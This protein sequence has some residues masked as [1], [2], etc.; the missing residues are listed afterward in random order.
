MK[1]ITTV[2]VACAALIGSTV[3]PAMTQQAAAQQPA[4]T[5][6]ATA[7]QPASSAPALPDLKTKVSYLIGL[8][9]GRDMAS[10]GVEVDSAALAAGVKDAAVNAKPAL[11]DEEM[12]SAFME[13]NTM[14]K[15][16]EGLKA[17]AQNPEMKAQYEKNTADAAAFLAENAKKEGVKTLPSGVQYKVVKEGSGATPKVTDTVTTHYKGTL[18]DG[19][20]FDSSYD[21]GQ[22][23]SFGVGEVI[24]GWTEALQKMK[25]GDK[26]ILYIPG[27]SAYGV[28]GRPGSIPPNALLT[29]EIEL[30]A[31]EGTP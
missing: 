22:P 19:K 25:V 12:R 3:A 11:S 13:F 5:P 29:F 9:I 16:K 26:W 14:L 28:M 30:I 7:P 23:A 15:E 24:A 27:K 8:N 21:R 18:L 20:V 4:A 31:V 1:R 6:A 17:L 10:K 2:A